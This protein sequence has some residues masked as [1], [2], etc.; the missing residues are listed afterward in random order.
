MPE[1]DLILLHVDDACLAQTTT[2]P[3]LPSARETRGLNSR[4]TSTFGN[5]TRLDCLH[6]Q[7]SSIPEQTATH[8]V[9]PSPPMPPPPAP[10]RAC[11][12]RARPR[13]AIRPI[14]SSNIT[15]RGLTEK[16]NPDKLPEA[17]QG[18][19]GPN[20]QQQEHVSEEA[21]KIAK[22]QGGEGP[23]LEQGTPVEEVSNHHRLMQMGYEPQERLY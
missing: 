16:N 12:F 5:A 3:K 22:I 9:A 6:L 1:Q 13:G 17:P 19:P 8:C 21:A 4:H 7:Q 11:V 2:P 10:F 14:R 18:E 15:I 23:D 20:T